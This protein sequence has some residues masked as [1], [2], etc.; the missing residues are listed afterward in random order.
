MSNYEQDDQEVIDDLMAEWDMTN[1]EI[2][3]FEGI[4]NIFKGYW[5]EKE[6]E[7]ERMMKYN[8]RYWARGVR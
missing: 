1:D 7:E 6:R 3:E 2:D 8:E 5:E 4:E